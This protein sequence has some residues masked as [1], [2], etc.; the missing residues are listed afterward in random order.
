MSDVVQVILIRTDLASMTTGRSVA[1]GCHA[2]NQMVEDIKGANNNRLSALLAEWQRQTP[3]GFGTCYVMDVNEQQ[4][5]DVIDVFSDNMAVIGSKVTDPS[6]PLKD[7]DV[8]HS[9]N[10]VTCGYL[11]GKKQDIMPKLIEMGIEFHKK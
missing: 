4:L 1:Q 9:L 7:G 3:S 2:A 5:Q 10:L 6:Y 8:V 11:F